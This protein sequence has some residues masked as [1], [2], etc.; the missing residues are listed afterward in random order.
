LTPV[1][2][3]QLSTL[4]TLCRA[5]GALGLGKRLASLG[6]KC[7]S[8]RREFDPPFRPTKQARAEF[9]LETP[10]LLAQRRLRDVKPCG[11]PTEMQLLRHSEKRPEVSQLHAG[12]IFETN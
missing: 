4:R 2:P 8:S 10:Y 12:M 1:L 7:L 9:I 5:D 11:S 6:E 3:Y